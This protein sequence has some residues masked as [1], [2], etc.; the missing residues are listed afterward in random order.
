M[1]IDYQV[2][3]QK[4][5]KY[6]GKEPDETFVYN[7]IVDESYVYTYIEFSKALDHY[8]ESCKDSALSI[9]VPIC[10]QINHIIQLLSFESNGKRK[11]MYQFNCSSL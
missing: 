10:F 1:K 2:K 11:I 5:S 4:L 6:T 8:K 7:E 9:S 3:V